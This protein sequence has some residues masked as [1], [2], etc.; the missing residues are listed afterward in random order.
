VLSGHRAIEI[1][2]HKI[3]RHR[4]A[5]AAAQ[6]T[7]PPEEAGPA[8]VKA[9]GVD[10]AQMPNLAM[11]AAI[12]A[13]DEMRANPFI[14]SIALGSL[15][16]KAIFVSIH[17]HRRVE[18]ESLLTV[19][20]LWGRLEDTVAKT[21]STAH[22]LKMPPYR[23]FRRQLAQLVYDGMLEMKELST[24]NEDEDVVTCGLEQQEILDGL[25]DHVY[26]PFA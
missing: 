16:D 22:P 10:G 25:R 9:P 23:L 14:E 13:A 20:K 19:E 3:N 21:C 4:D 26:A 5:L 2:R 6:I 17:K 12:Q 1:Y 18:G 8:A 15:L 11:A 7:A 24:Y